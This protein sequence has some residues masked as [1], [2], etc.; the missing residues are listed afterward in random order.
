MEKSI[1]ISYAGMTRIRFHGFDLS[2]EHGDS[3]TPIRCFHNIQLRT[4]FF[5]N[6][7]PIPELFRSR[8]K[9]MNTD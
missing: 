2:R 4:L 8:R 5:K 3:G 1:A 6:P 9:V 7:R